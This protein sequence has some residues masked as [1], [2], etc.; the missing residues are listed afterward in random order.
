M[1]VGR[2]RFDQSNVAGKSAG[3]DVIAAWALGELGLVGEVAQT[4]LV[5]A[6]RELNYSAN[7]VSERC[8]LATPGR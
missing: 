1:D 3:R 8:V 2:C 4:S 7:V 6:A 5:A